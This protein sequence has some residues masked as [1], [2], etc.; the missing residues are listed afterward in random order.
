MF[1]IIKGN[2]TDRHFRWRCLWWMWLC[3]T[4]LTEGRAGSEIRVFLSV[5]ETPCRA[6]RLFVMLAGL[7]GRRTPCLSACSTAGT[8]TARS[9]RTSSAPGLKSAPAPHRYA[10]FSG[11]SGWRKKER[12]DCLHAGC[13]R[14]KDASRRYLPVSYVCALIHHLLCTCPQR[15]N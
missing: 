14:W 2:R 12:E 10:V 1:H 5:Q 7:S 11:L 4:P 3:I 13:V 6:W 8:T 15:G 9:H